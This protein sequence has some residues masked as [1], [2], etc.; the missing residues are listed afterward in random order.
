MLPRN[1]VLRFGGDYRIVENVCGHLLMARQNIA[2][3]LSDKVEMGHISLQEANAW[4][5]AVLLDNPIEA[6]KL[7]LN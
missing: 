5:K 7:H 6:Y 1:K 3:A 2:R 4:A